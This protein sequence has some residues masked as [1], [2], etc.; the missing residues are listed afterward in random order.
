MK[1]KI[2]LTWKNG[3]EGYVLGDALN[4][5]KDRINFK[6]LTE[7]ASAPISDIIAIYPDEGL[8][9]DPNP[10]LVRS[11]YWKNISKKKILKGKQKR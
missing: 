8:Y 11:P 10:N 6:A 1:V 3:H 2:R 9:T 4:L 7:F 5:T